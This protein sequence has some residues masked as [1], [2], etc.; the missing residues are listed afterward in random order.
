LSETRRIVITLPQSLVEEVDRLVT[1]EK[2]SRSFYIREAM[3]L[4]L[5]ERKRHS[6][7]EQM[8]RGYLEMAQINLRL[9]LEDIAVDVEEEWARHKKAIE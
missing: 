9:A 5:T 4:Y 3:Q 2:G 7:R 6:L 8:K 1:V